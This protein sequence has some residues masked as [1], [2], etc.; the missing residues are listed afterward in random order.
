[1]KKVLSKK[2]IKHFLKRYNKKHNNSIK[3]NE[4]YQIKYS[5][6]DLITTIQESVK[7]N[8][9]LSDKRI[10]EINTEIKEF[11]KENNIATQKIISENNTEIKEFVKEN[12]IL[13]DKRISENNTEIKE[14]I[15]EN[16]IA[17]QKIILEIKDSVKEN[18]ILT[19]KK[20]LEIKESFTKTINTK[21]EGL[22]KYINSNNYKLIFW[23]CSIIV[24][25]FGSSFGYKFLLEYFK[26]EDLP[27]VENKSKG[28]FW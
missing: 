1:M 11:V 17:T 20:I 5:L 16:N 21:I 12:N 9:I 14:F 28:W 3:T 13:S 27:K 4:D 22:E 2:N 24:T 8:N 25:L 7:E 15:K 23:M 10:S 19:D 6:K 26:I 18:M